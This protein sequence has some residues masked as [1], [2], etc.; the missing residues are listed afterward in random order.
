MTKILITG[1]AGAVGRPLG[2]ELARRGHEVYGLDLN[3]GHRPNE[4]RC[5]I[6]AFRQ[7]ERVFDR[8]GDFDVVYHTAGE[9]GR[10]NGEEYYEQ[11]WR[12]NAV[13]TKNLL[14]LQER[15]GFRMVFFSSSEVYGDYDDVMAEEVPER[16]PIRQMNDYAISKWVNELQIMNSAERHGTETVRVRLFNTYGPGEYYSPYRSVV[17][18]FT[19]RALHRRPYTVFLD[20]HRTSTYIDDTVR[21]LANISDNFQPGA[22]YNLCGDEYHDIR[23]LSD[24]ILEEVGVDD[25]LVTYESVEKHNTRDKKGDNAAA[26]RDLEFEPRI[27][28]AEGIRRTVAWQRQVYGCD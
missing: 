4:M 2:D 24:L 1:S 20:H 10:N 14:R 3:H 22:I 18:L 23:Q 25:G 11:L 28:L 13:G 12:T 6:G 21:A 26:K 5:D 16:H 19:W 7:L 17:C 9:F 27:D 8:W 15:R